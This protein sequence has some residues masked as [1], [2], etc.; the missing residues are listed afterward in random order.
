MNRMVR[1]ALSWYYEN[2]KI[3]SSEHEMKNRIKFLNHGCRNKSYTNNTSYKFENRVYCYE[4]IYFS[5]FAFMVAIEE[6]LRLFKKLG[7]S[8]KLISFHSIHVS[9]IITSFLIY[10]AVIIQLSKIANC[11]MEK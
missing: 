11:Q 7:H 4:S 9:Y 8:S 6:R 3:G 5:L 10:A 1:Q 2:Y